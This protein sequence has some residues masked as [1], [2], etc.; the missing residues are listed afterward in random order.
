MKQ[1][2]RIKSKIKSQAA[3]FSHSYLCPPKHMIYLLCAKTETCTSKSKI[4]GSFIATACTDQ[5]VWE[6]YTNSCK[7]QSLR[8]YE[9]SL[10][11]QLTP[12]LSV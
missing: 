2:L 1:L 10:I 5:E 3:C 8:I 4:S 12:Q 11:S 7:G 9:N 6:C